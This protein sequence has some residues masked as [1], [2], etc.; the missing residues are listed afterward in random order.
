MPKSFAGPADMYRTIVQLSA[1]QRLI[2]FTD[3]ILSIF[4]FGRLP[5]YKSSFIDHAAIS[6]GYFCYPLF[7]PFFDCD[8][9]SKSAEQNKRGHP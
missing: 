3:S 9:D 2:H 7:K 8:E 1:K 4:I 6:N 5:S